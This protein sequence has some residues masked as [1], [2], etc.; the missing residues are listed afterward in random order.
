MKPI[1]KIIIILIILYSAI[2]PVFAEEPEW[3][4]PQEKTMRM[5]ESF[6][7]EGYVI[8]ATDF[9]DYSALITVFDAKGNLVTRNLTRIHDYFVV[10][11]RLNITIIDLQEV[12]GNIGANLGLNVSVD[13]W[14]KIET[15][16]KGSP[17]LKLSIIPKG[18]E[19]KNRT[20]VMRTY[21]PGSE[22]PINFSIRNEG[23]AKLKDMILKINTSLS[24]LYN[25]KLNYE[26]LELGAGNESDV[27]TVRFQA[28]YTEERKLISI[29][30]EA[31]GYDIFGKAYHAA[32]SAFIEVTPQFD[33]KIELVK[34][35]SEKVYMGDTATVSLSIKNNGSY[36]IDNVN[37]TESLPPGIEPIG[38]NLSWNFNL[39]PLEQKTVSY[40]VKPQK[41]GTYFF[42]PGSSIIEYKG[43]LD[44]N[45]K[46]VKLM[47][48][49][50]YVV[51]LKSASSYDPVKGERINITIEA[52]NLGDATA[53]VKLID[54]IPMNYS[55][56]SED[57]TYDNI[58]DTM[59]LHPGV[60]GSFSYLVFTSGT[61]NFILP[62]ARATILDKIM[63]RDER[64]KQNATSAELIIKVGEP[65]KTEPSS[66][67]ITSVPQKSA[68]PESIETNV[69]SETPKSSSGFE[70]YMFIIF[71]LA[72]LVI[73]KLKFR[74]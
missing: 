58:S 46:P 2:Y 73:R 34:Y 45:K 62:P 17:S 41:P 39:E 61:G 22:I 63:Y 72:I 18:I 24:V 59:V 60:S 15:R 11:D 7:R 70:G 36:K 28:P 6:T 35:V 47:V 10:N 26:I 49:G 9:Y 8:E 54:T 1:Y 43:T 37:L 33:N 12:R 31:L 4:D 57:Q 66:V 5:T 69:P 38:T 13:Q 40:I 48:G 19:I 23:K 20:I 32:D 27:I 16:L 67:K 55:L 68:S 51:L 65:L 3:V 64:Y 44:Y 25:E 53:I 29:S 50:P 71:F 74:K 42:L 14:V 30:V 52:K 21:I 56:A